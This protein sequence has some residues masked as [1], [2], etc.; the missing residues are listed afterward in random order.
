MTMLR[1]IELMPNVDATGI[2]YLI[3]YFLTIL[4]YVAELS[5]SGCHGIVASSPF[6]IH[7]NFKM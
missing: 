5:R 1:S 2:F 4:H 7:S 3:Y 6:R